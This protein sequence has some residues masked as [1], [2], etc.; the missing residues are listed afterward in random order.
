[1]IQRLSAAHRPHAGRNGAHV[2]VAAAK[3]QTEDSN[4]HHSPA[5]EM[6]N[7]G[8]FVF[9]F[10]FFLARRRCAGDHARDATRLAIV[11]R[12]RVEGDGC[13]FEPA[14]CVWDEKETSQG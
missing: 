12:A 5:Y 13:G 7:R 8:H 10:L 2:E 3:E 4:S 14:E 11:A 6:Y 9:F 1:V